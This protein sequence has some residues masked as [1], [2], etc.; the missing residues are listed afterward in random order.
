MSHVL[1]VIPCRQTFSK[2]N[3]EMLYCHVCS[4]D[5]RTFFF[6]LEIKF[7][8]KYDEMMNY[9]QGEKNTGK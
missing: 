9:R 5:T 2:T 3:V 6:F 8:I 1:V 7:S 4:N